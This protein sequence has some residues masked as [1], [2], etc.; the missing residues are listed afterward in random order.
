MA[1]V[2]VATGAPYTPTGILGVFAVWLAFSLR[3]GEWRLLDHW[4]VLRFTVSM[5]VVTLH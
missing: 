1:A 2:D 4:A 3:L 5:L